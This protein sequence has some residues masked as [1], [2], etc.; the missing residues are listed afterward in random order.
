MEDKFARQQ[1]AEQANA[2]AYCTAMNHA[3]NILGGPHQTMSAEFMNRAAGYGPGLAS[4]QIGSARDKGEIESQIDALDNQIK[5]LQFIA[6]NLFDRFSPILSAENKSG[7]S[8]AKEQSPLHTQL[9]SRL[10]TMNMQA[11][12]LRESLQ[13]II[14]RCKL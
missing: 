10:F 11:T 12:Q 1:Q 5:S 9:G 4:G 6:G 2:A 13:D 7:Q 8:S 14:D 3:A